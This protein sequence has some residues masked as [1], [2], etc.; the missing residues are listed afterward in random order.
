VA[1]REAMKRIV[2]DAID[3][4]LTS[5]HI[6]NDGNPQA[7]PMGMKSSEALAILYARSVKDYSK[8]DQNFWLTMGDVVARETKKGIRCDQ[9]TALVIHTL[10]HRRD[11][12]ASLAVIEQGQGNSQGHWFVAV[13]MPEDFRP[14]YPNTFGNAFV[15]DL[16]GAGVAEEHTSVVDPGRCI[17][18]CGKNELHRRAYF[19]GEGLGGG[20]RVR[21]K[22]GCFLTTACVE[23]KGLGDDCEELSVLRTY[24]DEYLLRT[25]KGR[26][27]VQEYYDIAPGIIERIGTRTESREIYLELYD[28][29][30]H[31]VEC[32]R[33]GK[34]EKA[35]HVYR[36]MVR[37]LQRTY[38]N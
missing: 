17:W 23:A 22:K 15:I 32:V 26:S 24:R 6:V 21:K 37:H 18:S 5:R 27:L 34:R 3:P 2:Y 38:G 33:Q 31:A 1:D 8:N 11:F 14:V 13:G 12:S 7:D 30:A 16:W 4:F 35:L 29:I 28:H 9:C 20:G 19:Q 25:E 10:S 36:A